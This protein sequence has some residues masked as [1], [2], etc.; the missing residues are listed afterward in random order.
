LPDFNAITTEQLIKESM[1][2]LLE[3]DILRF[4]LG[5]PV[6]IYAAQLIDKRT[7]VIFEDKN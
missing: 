5:K 7:T 1:N 3:L 4:S 6:K 2:Q